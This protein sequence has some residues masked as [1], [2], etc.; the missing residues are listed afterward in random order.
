MALGLMPA[1]SLQVSAAGEFP[2]DVNFNSL[3]DG[4][5]YEVP[6]IIGD[7]KFDV[8]N[9]GG[10]ELQ[11]SNPSEDIPFFWIRQL[12]GTE[13]L[14]VASNEGG[15]LQVDSIAGEFKLNSFTVQNQYN[16]D[17]TYYSDGFNIIGYKDGSAVPGAAQYVPAAYDAVVPVTFAGSVWGDIDQFRIVSLKG[18]APCDSFYFKFDDLDAGA[19]VIDNTPPELSGCTPSV[20]ATGVAIDTQLSLIF[21]ESVTAT[22]G[23]LYIKKTS[24]DSTVRTIAANSP[25]VSVSGGG[26]NNKFWLQP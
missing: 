10:N 16:S 4:N 9:S 25:Q 3:T 2:S 7:W 17:D 21:S 24:D 13:S 23:N 14:F 8:Y 12:S 6:S 1:L 19:P 22:A 18:T 5:F 11:N 15:Y 26:C 20:G